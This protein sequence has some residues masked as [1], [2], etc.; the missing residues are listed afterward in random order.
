M[1]K[2]AT[3]CGSWAWAGTWA[4]AVTAYAT[5]EARDVAGTLMP[6]EQ[7]YLDLGVSLEEAGAFVVQVSEQAPTLVAQA[8][9]A[10]GREVHGVIAGRL[11]LGVLVQ[12]MVVANEDETL[13]IW[14]GFEMPPF[15]GACELPPHP[16]GSR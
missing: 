3:S 12:M 5:L 10:A 14:V 8:R 6:D 7:D 2:T 4:A 9:L 1:T 13:E 16:N 15:A 11:G